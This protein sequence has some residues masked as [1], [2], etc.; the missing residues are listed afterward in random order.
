MRKLITEYL[1]EHSQHS[2]RHLASL[3]DT[4]LLKLYDETRDIVEDL[5]T[6]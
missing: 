4:T 1:L 5:L 6:L 2:E 3:N